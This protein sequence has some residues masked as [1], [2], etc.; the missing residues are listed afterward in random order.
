MSHRNCRGK[1]TSEFKARA[2]MM[3]DLVEPPPLRGNV[4]DQGEC[5]GRA[6]SDF[7]RVGTAAG[8]NTRR[9][10]IDSS[11]VLGSNQCHAERRTPL[12]RSQDESGGTGQVIANS[13]LVNVETDK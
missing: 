5:D 9:H 13:V 3:R 12:L 6:N 10:K 4:A 1:W 8:R 11:E 7:D 2:E